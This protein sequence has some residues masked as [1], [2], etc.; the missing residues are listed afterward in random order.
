MI[1]INQEN[2]I[3]KQTK[4]HIFLVL[5]KK[6]VMQKIFNLHIAEV[7]LVFQNTVLLIWLF[8]NTF[9]TTLFSHKAT[10]I[11]MAM[12][13]FGLFFIVLISCFLNAECLVSSG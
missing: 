10:P 7:F 3:Q 13:V 6:V 2:I 8:S 12:I 1:N 5:Q 4:Q 11:G 9:C